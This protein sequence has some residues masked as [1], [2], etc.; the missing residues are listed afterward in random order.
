MEESIADE[1][2]YFNLPKQVHKIVLVKCT[3]YWLSD[4]PLIN[5]SFEKRNNFLKIFEI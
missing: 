2:L 1:L 3:N 4:H 5:N